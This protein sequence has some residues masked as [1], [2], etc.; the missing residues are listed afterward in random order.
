MPHAPWVPRGVPAAEGC[1]LFDVSFESGSLPAALVYRCR[2]VALPRRQVFHGGVRAQ[3]GC[4]AC[5]RTC[6]A[7]NCNV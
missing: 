3:L 5:M 1:L 2:C 7:G 6:D 4:G